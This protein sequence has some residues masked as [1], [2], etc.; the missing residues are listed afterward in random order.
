MAEQTITN[1]WL[2]EQLQVI[3]VLEDAQNVV[4]SI[5]W[6]LNGTDG[7]N[8]A[9]MYGSAGVPEKTSSALIPY[10]ELT[11]ECILEWLHSVLGAETVSSYEANI[12]E[13]LKQLAKPKI[14]SPALPW[15]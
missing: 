1:T 15:S 14:I 9:T 4:T 7:I 2:I 8:T 12:A 10:E 13:Q 3:P 6:R 11:E 5:H